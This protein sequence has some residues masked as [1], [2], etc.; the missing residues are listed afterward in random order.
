MRH[1]HQR[2]QVD[3]RNVLE[4]GASR[5]VEQEIRAQKLKD[6]RAAIEEGMNSPAAPWEGAEAIK[7]TARERHAAKYGQSAAQE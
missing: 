7:R 4:Q 1:R 6:L 2:P 3:H 5:R